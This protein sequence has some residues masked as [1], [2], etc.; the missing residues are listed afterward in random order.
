MAA[1]IAGS[2]DAIVRKNLD[3]VIEGWNGAATRLFGYSADDMLGRSIRILI[4][5]DRS[6][7][8]EAILAQIRRGESV[9]RFETKRRRKDGSLVDI[10]LVVS[11]IRNESGVVVGACKVARDIT[12]RLMEREHQR[13][14]LD[15]MR[16][17]VKNLFALAGAI[18]SISAKSAGGESAMIDD[19]RARLVS[20]ARAHEL[21]MAD[22]PHD[23]G[24]RPALSLL[25]LIDRI[26]DPYAGDRRVT[27]GGQDCDVGGK[28]VTYLTLLL[29]ELATNA[30]KFGSLSVGDG[31]LDVGATIDGDLV[32]LLW[33][34]TGGP[35]PAAG[36][37]A[38]FGSRLER[39]LIRA[40]GAAIERDWRRTGLVVTIVVPCA[41]LAV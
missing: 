8:E 27:V 24:D 41:I 1:L 11:V 31:R 36:V 26:L 21:T 19:I 33:R 7:E 10:S 5:E 4:P 18:V 39:S 35:A 3:G 34:E 38:G 15:E 13:L 40:L 9:A 14:L 6:D 2:D 22:R 20:L 17:R 37:S 12:E 32:R 28:A 23:A 25:M 30:A 16:H 29:H